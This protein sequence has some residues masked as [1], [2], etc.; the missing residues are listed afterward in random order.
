M[1][2]DI[3]SELFPEPEPKNKK[4]SR[5]VATT[6]WCDSVFNIYKIYDADK[7]DSFINSSS[8]FILAAKN[9]KDYWLPIYVGQYSDRSILLKESFTKR[10]SL[11][12]SHIHIVN[13]EYK[14][15]RSVLCERVVNVFTPKLNLQKDEIMLPD[16]NE[17]SELKDIKLK[18]ELLYNHESHYLELI[19]NYKEEIKF[20]NTLQE[21]LRRERSQFFTQTLKEVI[22]T[23]KSAEVDA[24]ISAKWVE[25]LVA[26]Y[27]KSID[28]SGDLAR[29]HVIE[30]LSMINSEAKKGASDAKL[31]NITASMRQPEK[32]SGAK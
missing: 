11:G 30:I 26:N 18:L 17:S 15:Q 5:A 21:D 2:D 8:V 12:I 7:I 16:K 31:D 6:T 23:M 22:Q 19:K 25:D 3:L 32:P 27:T 28:L 20:A 10:K 13:V 24:S 14:S 9:K 29:T 4:P 1:I